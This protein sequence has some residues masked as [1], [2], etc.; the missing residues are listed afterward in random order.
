MMLSF[1]KNCLGILLLYSV[2]YIDDIV[3][4]LR[5]GRFEE[6]RDINI[7][8]TRPSLNS[9]LLF[10]LPSYIYIVQRCVIDPINFNFCSEIKMSKL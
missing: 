5:P 1:A 6:T 8:S 2:C 10:A 9:L 3:V 4:V 7:F